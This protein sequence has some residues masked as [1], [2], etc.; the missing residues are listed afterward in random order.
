MPSSKEVSSDDMAPEPERGEDGRLSEGITIIDWNGPDDAAN[1]QNWPSGKRWSHIVV[2]SLLALVTNMAPTMCAPA[3]NQIN[4]EFGIHSSTVSTLSVTLYVLG[5]GVGPM[6]IS[7]ISEVYG[8]LPVYHIS[9]LVF[10]AFLIGNALSQ[11]IAQFMLFRFLS[12]CVGGT[13]MAL[14]GGSIADVTSLQTRASAMGLFS[15]GPLTGPS[16]NQ[17]LGPVIGGFV[18]AGLGWR[19][20]F[21]LLTILGGATEIAAAIVMRET[22]ART[23]LERKT[24]RVRVATDNTKVHSKF[25]TTHLTPSRVLAQALL[26]PTRLLIRSLAVSV[27]SLYVAIVFGLLYLLLTTFPDVFEGSY[28]FTISTS[29]LSYL[30]LGVALIVAMVVFRTLGERVRVSHLNSDG[31][32][33]PRPELRLILMIW[34]SPFVGLGFFVYGWTAENQVHWIVPII[35]TSFIGFGA[36]FVLLY[37][38]DL[39]GPEA[40]ASALGANNFLR[41]LS[42]RFGN[43][44]WSGRC[45]VLFFDT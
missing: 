11:N 30:G 43:Q 33:Q 8:R 36:F 23:L 31:R 17:V 38:V 2:V 26:R 6:F 29:G 32:D 19:W 22:H 3:I 5:L 27:M 45:G 14:G 9:T 44:G 37:L 20:V 25:A 42:G 16:P 39:F 41:F 1:P 28:G 34:F 7:P 21:W 12:G 10:I 35:G 24:K 4:E 18:A 40:A 15:L 13:P